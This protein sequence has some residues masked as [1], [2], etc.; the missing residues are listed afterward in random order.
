MNRLWAMEGAFTVTGAAADH[1]MRVARSRIPAALSQL[2][3]ALARVDASVAAAIDAGF[4]ARL[5]VWAA[6]GVAPRAPEA[7]ADDLLRARGRGAVVVGPLLPTSSRPSSITC[8]GIT[9]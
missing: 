7:L 2:L 5:A 6:S 3:L 8:S 4:A 9:E 1:R